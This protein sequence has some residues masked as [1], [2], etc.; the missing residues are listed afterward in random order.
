MPAAKSRDLA[1][2]LVF[3]TRALKAP[4]LRDSAA[5]SCPAPAKTSSGPVMSRLCTWGYARIAIWRRAAS[6]WAMR[7]IMTER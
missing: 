2:E 4:A 5:I 6:E 1:A 7:A 3:L